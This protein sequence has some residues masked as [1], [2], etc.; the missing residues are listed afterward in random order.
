[1]KGFQKGP[2]PYVR[3][4]NLLTLERPNPS[5]DP[6]LQLNLI[7]HAKVFVIPLLDLNLIPF[8]ALKT[9]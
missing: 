6:L 8:D 2:L 7:L 4:S 5:P 9:P 3:K 1:V